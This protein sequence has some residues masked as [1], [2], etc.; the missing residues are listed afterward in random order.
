MNSG[1]EAK[2]SKVMDDACFA[3][4]EITGAQEHS[5]SDAV[6]IAHDRLRIVLAAVHFQEV[7]SGSPE[8][9]LV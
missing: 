1:D 9:V 4:G 5:L 6:R 3:S 8:A 7:G 2:P